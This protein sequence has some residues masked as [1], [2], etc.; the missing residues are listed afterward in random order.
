MRKSFVAGTIALAMTAAP[1]IAQDRPQG[2]TPSPQ[3]PAQGT[4]RPQTDTS[5]QGQQA[6]T[7]RQGQPVA[8]MDQQFA[9]DAAH[10]NM[11]EVEFGNL[12]KKKGNS[13]DVKK[14]GDR[15]V[16][17]HSKALTELKQIAQRKNIALPTAVDAKHKTAHD[18][19]EKMSG[20]AFDRAFAQQMVTGHKEAL[21][22]AQ[23]EAKSGSDAELK[24]FASKMV[25]SVQAHLKIAE[26]LAGGAV[27][28]SGSQGEPDRKPADQPDRKPNPGGATDQ[29]GGR[30][31]GTKPT[32]S[33][34]PVDR[35]PR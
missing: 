23:T 32:P 14:F 29:G 6:D 22:K 10:I 13:E 21:Q 35:E 3:T 27:G 11:A 24:A 20:A 28:T 30:T 7:A 15:L 5:R 19:L 9:M 25:D 16:T 18:Q 31:P 33:P 12:A 1:A 8:K 26:G 2:Q 34:N 4:S 17:D